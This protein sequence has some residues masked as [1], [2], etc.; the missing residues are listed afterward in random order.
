M[1]IGDIL[2]TL[3][4]RGIDIAEYFFRNSNGPRADEELADMFGIT[5]TQAGRNR[6]LGRALFG[7]SDDVDKRDQ[8]V[9]VSRVGKLSLDALHVINGAVNKLHKFAKVGKEDLRLQLSQI[10]PKLTVDEL[11]RQADATVRKANED[12]QKVDRGRRY[13]RTSRATDAAGMRYATLSLPE[14][15][16]SELTRRMEKIVKRLRKVN[17]TLTH[18]QAMADALV[19][20]FGWEESNPWLQP[21]VLIAMDDLKTVTRENTG[22]DTVFCTTEGALIS[23]REYVEQKIAPYGLVLLYDDHA[24]PV[25]LYRTARH[26]N[27]KQRA[28]ISLD[29]ILCADPECQRLVSRGE[30]HH[31]EAWK[32]GGETNVENLVGTCRPHNA[33]NDDDRQCK[34][35]YYLHDPKTGRAAYQPAD[36]RKPIRFNDSPVGRR[37]GRV[38]ALEKLGISG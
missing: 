11:K 13:F 22:E 32:H 5:K 12:V 33:Q 35:G 20:N 19:G 21:A 14:Q 8:A 15:E 16:M 23:A 28:M 36:P 34:N 3:G 38:W 10:A 24:Q 6:R 7:A 25:D 31:V 4:T 37:S 30:I 27:D 26:A 17:K 18:Q 29:Q 9:E 1:N 2:H